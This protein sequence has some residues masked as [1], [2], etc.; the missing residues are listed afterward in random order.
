L[1]PYTTLF[2]SRGAVVANADVILGL[3]VMDLWSAVNS[4]HDQVHRSSRPITKSGAKMISVTAGDLYMKAN[5]QDFYRYQGVD[6]AMAADAEATLPSLVEEVK[7]K[8]T[9]DRNP[10][11]QLRGAKQ[12]ATHP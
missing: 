7:R 9:S 4:F 5:Y 10:L 3:E 1:F 6:L 11:A 12:I 2:R 8:T